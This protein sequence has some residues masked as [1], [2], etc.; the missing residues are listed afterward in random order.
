MGYSRAIRVGSVIYVSGTT[1]TNKSGK[2]VG[3]RNPYKQAV[4]AIRNIEST[5]KQFDS[6]LENVVRIRIFVANIKD[7]KKIAKAHSEFFDKIRPT[8]TMV[9]VNRFIDPEIL[10]EIEAEAVV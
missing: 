2:I 5:L 6:N 8:C 7:W 9:E 10:V 3:K 4:Q 1:A